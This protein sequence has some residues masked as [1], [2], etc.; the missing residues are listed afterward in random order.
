MN[1]LLV[2]FKV[3][4]GA[5]VLSQNS[6]YQPPCHE[7]EKQCGVAGLVG[8][9]ARGIEP[10]VSREDHTDPWLRKHVEGPWDFSIE[11]CEKSIWCDPKRTF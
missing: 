3:L 1:I 8:R 10:S 6:K 9:N 4:I 11:S 2:V 7:L 5:A